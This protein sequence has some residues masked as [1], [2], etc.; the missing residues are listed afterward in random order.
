MELSS[1][2]VIR[3]NKKNQKNHT[4]FI[5]ISK[6]VVRRKKIFIYF[7]RFAKYEVWK[8]KINIYFLTFIDN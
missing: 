6:I 3:R 5:Q 4:F 2:K 8:K 7:L 1:V